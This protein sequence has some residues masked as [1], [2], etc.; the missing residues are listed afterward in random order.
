[1]NKEIESKLVSLLTDE[2][3]TKKDIAELL[4]SNGTDISDEDFST[5]EKLSRKE[6]KDQQV[7][8]QLTDDHSSLILF[9]RNKMPKDVKKSLVAIPSK[10]EARFLTDIYYQ[11]QDRRIAIQGQIRA[12]NQGKDSESIEEQNN[13]GNLMFMNWLLDQFEN[14]EYN[15]KCALDAFSDSYYISKWAKC[16]LGIGPVIATMLAANIEIKEGMHA[17]NIWSYAGLN[18]NNRPWL[19]RE[20]S[21]KLVE[22]CIGKNGGILD[23]QCVYMISNESKWSFKYLSEKGKNKKGAWSKEELIKACS[24]IPYNKDL[25]VLAFKIGHSFNMIKNKPESLYGRILKERLEY[26]NKK[27]LAGD[28]ADQAKKILETKN[29]GKS[30]VAYKYYSIGQLPPAHINQRCQRYATKLFLSHLFEAA[31]Y[32]KFG[33]KCP[34]PYIIG[35][36]ENGHND[37]IEPEVPYDIIERDRRH[38]D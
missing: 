37:Y 28:Y 9:T 8:Y 13:E 34:E 33:T 21:K 36:D 15:I 22:D 19:G 25:K 17:G 20:K 30:T 31:W 14:L 16:N 3:A 10:A 18:D 38:Y 5:I 6:L 7:D 26:E 29:I 27:N 12:L 23:D 4:M 1:M 32:N 11:T 2:S 24:M 35:F